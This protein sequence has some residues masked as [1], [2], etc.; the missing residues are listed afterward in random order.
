M[1]PALL[2]M[3]GALLLLPACA[4]DYEDRRHLVARVVAGNELQLSDGV[5]VRLLG[6]ADTPANAAA[7]AAQAAGQPVRLVFDSNQYPADTEP[8]ARLSAYVLTADGRSLNRQL[9]RGRPAALAPASAAYDSLAAFTAAAAGLPATPLPAAPSA[10]S[11]ASAAEPPGPDPAGPASEAA[12]SAVPATIPATPA[13]PADLSDLI[14]ELEPAVFLIETNGGSLGTG[15][16]VGPNGLAVSNHH[17]FKQANAWRVTLADGR[18]LPVVEIVEDQPARDYVIFRVGGELGGQVFLRPALATPRR[19]SPVYVI[20]NPNGLERTFTTGVVS[21]LRTLENPGDLIQ[22]DAAIS[23][24]SSGSPVLNPAGRVV[25]IATFK[26]AE[27]ENC[28]FAVNIRLLN[29][30]RFD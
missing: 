16:F 8:G 18:R 24:G 5:R 19:A 22:F 14:D 30:A 3:L 13:T 11:V 25:G 4:P 23:P 7:L 1:R 2:P 10:A 26:R 15:F 20:G 21:A 9:V 29:L 12:A 6:V 17:V 28:N 27:C